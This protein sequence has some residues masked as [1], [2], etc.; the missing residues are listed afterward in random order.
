MAEK[1]QTNIIYPKVRLKDVLKAFWCGI[2][3]KKW[4][5]F[6]LFFGVVGANIVTILVPIFYK[7]FFDLISTVSDKGIGSQKLI[8]II[9]EILVLNAIT[10]VFYRFAT[11]AN[12]VF[13]TSVMANLKQQAYDYLMNHSYN[14]FTNNFTGSLVQRVSRFA[15][16]FERLSDNLIWGLTPL[17]VRVISIILII[18]FI[19]K[20]IALIILIWASVF[21]GFNIIFSKWKLK[22]DLE[23]A[24]VD[25]KTTG[26]LADTITNQNNVTLFVGQNF[27][28][29]GY[30]KVTNDQAKITKFN[31]NLSA[32]VD[33]V[34][35]F[36]TVLIE[37]LIFYFAIKYW[38]QGL[39]T[40][41]FF[42]MLQ[43]YIITLIEQFWGV[44]RIVRDVYQS[45]A[46]A[47]EM[48]EIMLLP[49]E[50]LDI[51]TAVELKVVEGKIE[52]KD[53]NFNFNETRQVL[54]NINLIINPGEKIA[55]IGPSGA[56]KT[57]FVR[58][59]LRFYDSTSGQILIDAQDISKVTQESLRSNI[60]LV[61]QDPVLFH[62]TLAENIAYG[63]RNAT[64]QEI[65]KA[66]F[67]AHCDE[68][69][70]ELP[71]A[72][73]TYVGERGIKLSGGE[74]QRVAI[75]R[76]ILKNAP[77]LV[78][79]EATSSLDSNSE[80]LIQDALTNLMQDKTVIVIA[81]R[82]STIQKMDR[83]V[84]VD[85]GKIIEQGNHQELLANENS[86]Y[87]KLWTLQ[88]G[89]FISD[90]DENEPAQN[91]ADIE[92]G[93]NEDNDSDQE[94]GGSANFVEAKFTNF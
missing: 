64:R 14:F 55:L 85:N 66:A 5:G 47:K 84:V 44:T 28:S 20:W 27:E 22:Y 71:F 81:H 35:G 80:M 74:R 25:S 70:K 37:F 49:H 86:L 60:S 31:W 4:W 61:P 78:L 63:K 75:A 83:I 57:T 77:I 19:N 65:E 12:N 58:L 87:K 7:Q 50:V 23:V 11:F 92:E 53:L 67:L 34:Q 18:F 30:K 43:A 36:L 69:I 68:F 73:E 8:I 1:K 15:R 89:G 52:F 41:G 59:L 91:P 33:A 2:K 76:A 46:D 39:I 29:Q 54:K 62:R 32:I 90:K 93:E 17:V 6:L 94:N 88:A 40:I 72:L 3:P 45:Y 16:A 9:I 42:V 13:Q 51:K 26:Y 24:E 82:L 38:S 56:G 79:D 10:W 21:L 48:V